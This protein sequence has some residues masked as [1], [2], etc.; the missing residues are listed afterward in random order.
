MKRIVIEADDEMHQQVKI[1]AASCG[2]TVKKIVEELL[3]NWL[4]KGG[5]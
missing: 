4:K 5:K 3:K 2:M 1:K